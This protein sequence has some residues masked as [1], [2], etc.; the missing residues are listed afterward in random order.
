M[1]LDFNFFWYHIGPKKLI[2]TLYIKPTIK[3]LISGLTM[4][5]F[6][7]MVSFLETKKY[8]ITQWTTYQDFQNNVTILL[9][10]QTKAKYFK[11]QDIEHFIN[12]SKNFDFDKLMNQ[13]SIPPGICLNQNHKIYIQHT[14]YLGIK[15]SD[16]LMINRLINYKEMQK[17]SQ[18]KDMYIFMIGYGY[19][20]VKRTVN[21]GINSLPQYAGYNWDCDPFV[22]GCPK[23]QESD[24]NALRRECY[25][26]IGLD[27]V[28]VNKLKSHTVGGRKNVTYYHTS[29]TDYKECPKPI[30]YMGSDDKKRK[31]NAL[32][33]GEF[34]DMYNL[35]G[36]CKCNDV[37]ESIKY[38]AIINIGE[39]LLALEKRKNNNNTVIKY[40]DGVMIVENVPAFYQWEDEIGRL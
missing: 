33:Y 6:N 14:D 37:N 7:T 5:P 29:P 8:D 36:K 10:S 9:N 4:D 16:T 31:V 35:L 21:T 32:I 34:D 12:L 26:E 18:F 27:I 40:V 1:S 39:L 17:L 20:N 19:S 13:Y 28:D 25:E 30:N 15:S 11:D 2:F 38:Y 22:G 23:K 3:I 24:G